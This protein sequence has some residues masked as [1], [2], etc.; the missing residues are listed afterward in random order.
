MLTPRT[1]LLV[2]ESWRDYEMY[3]IDMPDDVAAEKARQLAPRPDLRRAMQP[4]ENHGPAA[5]FVK[6]STTDPSGDVLP[7][8]TVTLTGDGIATATAVSDAN[9]HFWLSAA[10]APAHFTLQ[11]ELAGF[12]QTSRQFD[13]A[14]SGGDVELT[15]HMASVSESI[16]VTAGAPA[17][18]VDGIQEP[19]TLPYAVGRE[20]DK[21]P[22]EQRHERVRALVEHIASLRS[23]SARMREY[24]AAC[25]VAGGEKQLHI[26]VAEA[27]RA[28]DADLALRVLTDLAE[29]YA[30]DAPIVRIVARIADGWGR[31][32]VARDLLLHALEVSPMEPQTWRELILL[33]A[34]EG[35]GGELA[36]LRKR[37]QAAAHD[38]RMR[39]VDEQIDRELARVRPGDDARLDEGAALQVEL[40]W[41][42]NYSYV[43]IH[44]VEP[45]GEEVTWNHA[46]SLHGGSI[47]GWMT[48]GFGPEIYVSRGGS[49]GKYRIDVQYYSSDGTEVSRETL[50]HVIVLTRGR[51]GVKRTDHV[52]VLSKNDERRNVIDVEVE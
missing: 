47:V 28:D 29:A 23:V 48:Q 41:D 4:P 20:I 2:L 51:F 26:G 32:D 35:R 7:G 15:M 30:D 50:A 10:S 21:L 19:T 11:A 38:W 37:H 49:H 27:L 44:V 36:S 13:A 22:L 46:K 16:T 45:S 9:G 18:D 8:V 42:S 43:D 52:I 17:F 34:R 12:N 3:G 5:W 6:G 39:E 1:S 25:V 24:A 31:A 40:M 33:A 14:P